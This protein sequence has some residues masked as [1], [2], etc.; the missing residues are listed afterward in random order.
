MTKT[1]FKNYCLRKLG[2]GMITVNVTPDQ[3]EDR[4]H[5][6][7]QLFVDKH[8]DSTEG[9]WLLYR[10]SE[11]DVKNGYITLS[12]DIKIVDGLLEQHTVKEIID[13]NPNHENKMECHQFSVVGQSIIESMTSGVYKPFDNLS[14]YIMNLGFDTVK[15]MS[16][17]MPRFEYT[18]HKRKLVI[19]DGQP[20]KD[21]VVA[22]H[23]KRFIPME[24][25]FD[26]LWFKKYATAK[27]KEQ[28][29][30]NLKKHSNIEHLG[31]VQINGQQIYDEAIQEIE[32]LETKLI[33]QYEVPPMMTIG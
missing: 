1:E 33:E 29:G 22:I 20:L 27:I 18:F 3:V 11:E 24:E 30:S 10:T 15:D 16:G 9:E 25:V 26:D 21:K 6:A 7:Y 23:V 32:Q 4:I 8:Y 5:E 28:W 2:G 13:S 31:G 14:F 19:Y 17:L 12:D